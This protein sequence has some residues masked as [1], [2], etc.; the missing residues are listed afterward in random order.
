MSEG[1]TAR[2]RRA[3][4][5]LVTQVRTLQGFPS[6]SR[7]SLLPATPPRALVAPPRCCLHPHPHRVLPHSPSGLPSL[8][9][10]ASLPHGA[11]LP[12]AW[13]TWPCCSV[14]APSCC[15]ADAH[16]QSPICD[17][18]WWGHAGLLTS[19]HASHLK[20]GCSF[21]SLPVYWLSS[22][23]A[24]ALERQG[25]VCRIHPHFPHSL[26]ACGT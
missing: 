26:V 22:A 23:G 9:T 25:L 4:F 18:F 7:T 20:P 10:T 3:K 6:L 16:T 24:W 13:D 1:T 19:W 5:D 12:S 2:P 14:S 11:R 8:P 21:I 17:F 15:A